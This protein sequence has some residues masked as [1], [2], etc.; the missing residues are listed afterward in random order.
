MDCEYPGIIFSLLY[1]E[2]KKKKEVY[3]VDFFK[4]SAFQVI[5]AKKTHKNL[6]I[7][8]TPDLQISGG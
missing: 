8:R 1:G 2:K 6:M 5:N 4:D 7:H 3:Y